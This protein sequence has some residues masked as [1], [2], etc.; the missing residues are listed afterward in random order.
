MLKKSIFNIVIIIILIM[1][2]FTIIKA[3]KPMP[4]ILKQAV[5]NNIKEQGSNLTPRE[6]RYYRVIEE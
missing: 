3:N 1:V 2:S 6:A 5:I 4:K